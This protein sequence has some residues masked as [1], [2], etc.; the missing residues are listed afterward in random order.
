MGVD[1]WGLFCH[2][3]VTTWSSTEVDSWDWVPDYLLR[4]AREIEPL[5]DPC[6]ASGGLDLHVSRPWRGHSSPSWYK[7]HKSSFFGA[8]GDDDRLLM[9]GL[10]ALQNIFCN[11]FLM[12]K[13][14]RYFIIYCADKNYWTNVRLIIIY[15]FMWFL[16]IITESINTNY[17]MIK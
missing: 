1:Y 8:V 3:V 4:S 10:Y 14:L 2:I 12:L 16:Q 15:V 6:V 5:I 7:S 17:V 9:L 11:N 13:L